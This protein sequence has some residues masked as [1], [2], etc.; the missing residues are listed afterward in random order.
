[1][2]GTAITAVGMGLS[3][4]GAYMQYKG[5]KDQAKAQ[6][7]AA[8]SQREADAVRRQAMEFDA[9]RRRRENIRQGQMARALA[10]SRAT[11]QG[12]ESGSGLEGGI[13]QISGRTGINLT[14]VQGQLGFGRS[15]F[16]INAQTSSFYA[17]AAAA[18]TRSSLGSGLVSL[19]GAVVRNQP[20][21]LRIYD[22]LTKQNQ[23]GF[24]DSDF[25]GVGEYPY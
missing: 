4:V 15:I 12:A 18:G 21:A 13:G 25:T 16:D 19:G 5:S 24:G 10:V 14:G 20:A 22:Y 11:N 17:Q 8:A 3:G 6:N 9:L 1:M 2:A 7:A 23:Q